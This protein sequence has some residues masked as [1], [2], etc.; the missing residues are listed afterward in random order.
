[1]NKQLR[2]VG[3]VIVT[4][5]SGL[6]ALAATSSEACAGLLGSD[7]TATLY[8]PDLSTIYSGPSG[9]IVVSSSIEFPVGSL[10]NDGS[11]D[12]TDTQII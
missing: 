1:M 11:L 3:A 5:A 4:I 12:I 6:I 7:V 8:D 2:I 10:A 9:P